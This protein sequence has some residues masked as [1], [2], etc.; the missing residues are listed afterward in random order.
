[1]PELILHFAIPFS[2]S[3]PI[4]GIK[5]AIIVGI[6]GMLPDIDVLLH[7]HRSMT[8]SLIILTI[9]S[10][11]PLY[12]AFFKLKEKS[13][14]LLSFFSLMIHP[15]MDI[16]QTYTPI[17]Y[18]ISNSSFQI[19]IKGSVLISR[20][21]VPYIESQ[22]SSIPT[23]F[24]KFLVM[25]AP[26]FTSE[27]FIVSLILIVAPFLFLKFK[28]DSFNFKDFHN[29]SINNNLRIE[30][31]STSIK[32][33]DLT[34]VIPTL[35]EVKAIG[36]VID[37]LKNEGYSNILIVDGYSNDGTI[38]VVRNK[39]INIVFQEGKGKAD[40]IRTGI[41]FV[42][43]PFLIVM[44][45]DYTY[46]PKDIKKFLDFSDHDEV[47]GVRERKNIPKIHRFGN[48]I[49]TKVFNL[50]FGTSLR[51]VCSGMYLLRTKVAREI[52]FESKGF[53]VEVEVAAHVATTSKRIKEV[54]INYRKRIG[55]P[56]LK[57]PHGFSIIFSVIRLML[58]YNPVF[59]IFSVS[60]ATLVP[61]VAIIGYVL[62]E[63]IFNGIKHHIWAI[64]GISLSGVG[65]ISLLLAILVLYLK[66]LEYRIMERLR[67]S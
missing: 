11:I 67:K 52:G 46:D 26:I 15:I 51:D 37:E 65:F 34:I 55:D 64:I 35:N 20:S 47:I 38:E 31:N 19:N 7:V 40:A 4:I 58:R 18:P 33:E 1:M 39:N 29:A 10:L 56:K 14:A 45:G 59:F 28:K 54:E 25:D 27:G 53:S 66:R 16:F 6:I 24:Q 44:D 50:L 9:I 2:I 23:N 17:L 5:R 60:S 62:Y 41:K 21:I 36:K 42:K 32:K 49:I 13:L 48:W 61:G 8:H 3:A 12:I 57:S 63:L 43:T 30:F 22:V